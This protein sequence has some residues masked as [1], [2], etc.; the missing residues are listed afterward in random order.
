MFSF[1][2][3]IFQPKSQNAAWVWQQA[4]NLTGNAFW[5][6][7]L[8]VH[9]I[10]Q[11]DTYSLAEPAHLLLD[12]DEIKALSITLNAHFNCD[13][14]EFFWHKNQWLLKMIKNPHIETKP[15][16]LAVNK[17]IRGFL[18]TSK[19]AQNWASFINEVQMLLFEHP[20]NVARENGKKPTVNS[21][22]CYGLSQS[23]QS[24]KSL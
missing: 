5:M 1:L 8:P 23:K 7:A 24:E 21:L 20:V 15:P 6:F 4:G 2:K 14:Y 18:P 12:D 17:D 19:G 22:W 9:L 3:N 10:L 16:Q 13:G 11:R